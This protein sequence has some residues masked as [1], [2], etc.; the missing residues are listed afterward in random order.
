MGWFDNNA[1]YRAIGRRLDKIETDIAALIKQGI[2]LMAK[3]DDARVILT[4]LTGDVTR[5]TTEIGSMKTLLINL[6]AL[7]ADL[8][9]RLKNADNIPD[10][11]LASAQAA[12]D[13][14]NKNTDEIIKSVTDNTPSAG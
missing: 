4:K 8:N 2:Q 6:G 12:D 3:A 10:D 11:I 14:V 1:E 5:Q 13:A 7:I 9:D